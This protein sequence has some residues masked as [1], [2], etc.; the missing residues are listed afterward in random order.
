VDV[1]QPAPAPRD[2]PKA[3]D[4]HG[5]LPQHKDEP[6]A[7]PHPAP[8]PANRDLDRDYKARVSADQRL[9]GYERSSDQKDQKSQKH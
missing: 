3:T 9:H 7:Q 5:A 8:A 2:E 4:I 1:K 6:A